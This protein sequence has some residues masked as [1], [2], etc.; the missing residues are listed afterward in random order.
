MRRPSWREIRTLVVLA[1]SAAVTC[2]VVLVADVMILNRVGVG[3]EFLLP[4]KAAR[5]FLF[6]HIEPYSSDVAAF[7]QRSVYG[8]PAHAG[9]NLYVLDLPFYL[10]LLYIPLSLPRDPA[11]PGAVWLFLSQAAL[12]GLIWA[13]LRLTDWQPRAAFRAAFFLVCA[14]SLY[15]LSGFLLGSPIFILGLLYAGILMSMLLEMDELAGALM[16]LAW[17]RWEVG[18]PFMIFILARVYAQQ[19]WRVLAG[20][21]MVT[22]LLAAIAFFVYPDWLRAFLRAGLVILRADFGSSPG[23]ILT[24]LWPDLGPALGWGITAV[25]VVLLVLEWS[26]GRRAEFRRFYWGACLTLA[27]TPLLGLRTESANLVV[28]ILPLALIFSV[29]RERWSAGYWLATLVLMLVFLV[30]WGLFFGP[31]LTRQVRSDIV[32]IFLPVFTTIGLYWIRWWALRPPRTWLERA[33]ST[34]FR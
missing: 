21:G 9:E 16:A 20:F 24:R 7:V 6:E 15:S 28:L 1:L 14:L 27:L 31:L 10:L 13:S 18:L 26:G 34:E 17:Y 11:L 29:L 19:R 25:T 33:V 2:A 12:L 4:W 3:G 23:V 5:A 30:P 32:F 22:G 8:R